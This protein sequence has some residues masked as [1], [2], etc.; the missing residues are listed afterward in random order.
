MNLT[1]RSFFRA[2][3]LLAGGFGFTGI[4]GLFCRR[5]LADG[6]PQDRKL[7]FLFQNGGNDG[8][9]TVIPRGDPEY[10]VTNRPSLFIPDNLALDTG[11]G[12]AQLH[13]RLAP[14]ME[15]FHHSRLNGQDGPG[16]L[17]ILHRIGYAGQSQS[18]FDSQ[19]YWQNGVP[20]QPGL[21]EGMFYR[22]LANTIDLDRQAAG[23]V[24]AAL[25]GSQMVALK[26][27]KPVPNFTAASQFN[28][29]G[30]TARAAKFLGQLPSTPGAK[31]GEGWLGLYG[32][33]PEGV[34]RPYQSLIH[35]TGQLLGGTINT[36]QEAVQMGAYTPEN[37]ALYPTGTL[38][39]RLREAA[40][41]FKR[42]PVRII[43]LN[44]GG[45]DTHT[46][47]GQING[48][49]GGLLANL[50][51]GFQALYRD[52][53]GQWDKLLV[54]T[55]TEFGRTSIENGSGGTD[56][57]D[58]SVV[59]AAGGNVRGGV[60]NCDAATWQ[61]GDIFSKSGRYLSRRTD[62]RAVFGEVFARHFGDPPSLLDR[63]RPGYTE[64][65]A[66]NPS[67]FQPLGFLG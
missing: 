61:P 12:F 24:A 38:G 52:L 42:T 23:F 47:Q 40:M 17:A 39:T 30:T 35:R 67:T 27:A 37:G 56:H 19:Q 15:I 3:M 5:L 36:L 64:A 34:T 49:H 54:I 46:N 25:A 26:G 28:V 11:N 57:A 63:I 41:L 45:W 48:Y 59:F 20:G 18:H 50:A 53:A 66:A 60:Y 51:Q 13:P 9:N 8:L 65:A 22:H 31:D 21:E 33:S 55:M 62:F 7:L 29:L 58:S 10:N 14:M 6:L 1:R 4:P 16:N 44:F 43:G 2:S 32:A